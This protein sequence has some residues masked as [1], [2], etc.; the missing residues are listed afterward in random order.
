M[1]KLKRAGAR[2][3]LIHAL[4]Q[5]D[6]T[7][8]ISS[9][10]PSLPSGTEVKSADD[11]EILG[12]PYVIDPVTGKFLELERQSV[13]AGMKVRAMGFGGRT[14]VRFEGSRSSVRL[15]S[16]SP[17]RFI[18]RTGDSSLVDPN[19]VVNLDRLTSAKDHR[20]PTRE[21]ESNGNGRKSPLGSAMSRLEPRSAG[22]PPFASQQRRR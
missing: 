6:A 13:N 21:G 12:I 9:G 3:Q 17:T 4:L 5:G 20:E 19:S 22:V 15:Q 1:I 16:A 18:L 8:T 11:P 14:V 10:T 2:D 7:Q